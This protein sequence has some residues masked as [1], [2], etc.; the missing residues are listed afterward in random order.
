MAKMGVYK[1]VECTVV[2]RCI[3]LSKVELRQKRNGN[4]G[5]KEGHLRS[6]KELQLKLETVM[7]EGKTEWYLGAERGPVESKEGPV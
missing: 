2:Q 7:V 1:R 4:W 6:N 5:Q 3:A